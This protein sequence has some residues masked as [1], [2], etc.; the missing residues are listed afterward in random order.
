MLVYWWV[1]TNELTT[2]AEMEFT[3]TIGHSIVLLAIN[4]DNTEVRLICEKDGFK[5]LGWRVSVSKGSK[6][7]Y[8]SRLTTEISANR[9]FSSKQDRNAVEYSC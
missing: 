8:L 2:V 7:V 4:P 5:V 9:I 3:M 1:V 6:V